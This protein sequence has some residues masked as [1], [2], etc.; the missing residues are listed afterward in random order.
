MSGS[1]VGPTDPCGFGATL[2]FVAHEDDDLLFQS[3]TILQAARA[4]TCVRT[5]Y[6]SAGDAGDEESYWRDREDGV[7]AA[8]ATMLEVSD[9]W[10]IEDAGVPDHPI[11]LSS[12]V[13]AP[14]VSLAF[15]RLPDGAIDGD[16]FERNDW[17]SL[18]KLYAQ[19]ISEIYA[20]DG[21]SWYTLDE[22][23]ETMLTLMDSFQPDMINTLDFTE[24]YGNG[25]H[26]DHLTV[27]Y[28]TLLA[29]QAY[30]TPH[31]FAGHQ[32]YGI[33]DRPS[34]VDDPDLSAKIEAFLEYAQYDYR[35][36]STQAACAVR[37]ESLWLSRM[38]TV[39]TPIP[40]P[41]STS[42]PGSIPAQPPTN[43]AGSA[44][45]TASSENT[46]TGQTAQG[47]VDGV[48]DG[49]PGDHTK[50]WAS[51]GGTIGSTLTLTW[52]DT[53]I[54]SSVRLHDRPNSDDHITGGTLTFSDGSIVAVPALDDAGGATTVVFPPRDTT[55]IRFTVTSVTDSTRNVGLA[56]I[57][58]IGSPAAAAD[59]ISPPSCDALGRVVA[60]D[61]E[62]TP[63]STPADAARAIGRA[64]IVE[65]GRTGG[66]DAE[67]V[68]VPL[69]LGTAVLLVSNGSG[70][71]ARAVSIST[72][73]GGPREPE[74]VI[75][76]DVEFASAAGSTNY[77]WRDVALQDASGARYAARAEP[78]SDDEPADGGGELAEGESVRRALYFVVPPDA[79]SL[80]VVLLG[81][82]GEPSAMWSLG[83]H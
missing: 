41:T 51:V 1:T 39:G 6:L 62:A 76:A 59:S 16:G 55:S 25:D 31:G 47:A 21:S 44:V 70:L 49:F 79:A 67:A 7:R 56:E 42:V 38:Y 33:A 32:G 9:D 11:P 65:A 54:V 10:T 20:V 80:A 45:V 15:L 48:I 66:L 69:A 13:E 61:P 64:P 50:E 30:A 72:V 18:Q 82:D 28:L 77:R 83:S 43:I 58:V 71:R 8:Y 4:G 78:D 3:P 34:N 17:E 74:R 46:A 29:Q 37:Q 19:S 14:H 22:L 68:S 57:E 73:A 2:N 81:S 52:S 75:R 12:L 53:Q 40:P 26:S 60:P 23:V 63:G 24:T 36:C 5:V 27:A 35:T